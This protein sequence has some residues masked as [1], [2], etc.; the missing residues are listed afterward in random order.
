VIGKRSEGV[1]AG[2]LGIE[3]AIVLPTAR[4][5]Q[6]AAIKTRHTAPELIVRKALHASGLRF[7][8]HR[9]DLPG[10]P[11]IVLPGHRI[12]VFVHGCFWHGC[13]MCD[14][15]TRQPKS[16]AAFWSAKLDGNRRRDAR[17]V[18]ELTQLG[19]HVAIV[20]DCETR[21]REKLAEAVARILAVVRPGRR[22]DAAP[23]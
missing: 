3:P 19:W 11:D 9:R 8:L 17:N 13:V 4:Q 10:R 22:D 14:R 15:G 6:M 21:N 18:L 5:R 16:N 20:W 1:A 23:V 7:R 12:A 2:A